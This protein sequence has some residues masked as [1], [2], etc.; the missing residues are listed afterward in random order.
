[1]K[2]KRLNY[3]DIARAFAI[4]FIVLGHTIVHSQHLGLLF[5]LLY[6]FH[7]AL[8]FIL[9][10][11]VFT[12]KKGESFLSFFKRK[13]LR[14]MIPYF[15]WALV[16]LIPYMI[17]GGDIGSKLGINSSF[18]LK[19]MLINVLYGNGNMEALK[20]NTSLWFLP[21]LFSMEIIYYF[22][23]KFLKKNNRAKIIALFPIILV[24]FLS[25]IYLNKFII[26][27]FG[28]N[29]VLNIGIFFYIGF[30][31]REFNI[32]D[33][34]INSC[35]ICIMLLIGIICCFFNYKNVSCVGYDYGN[36]VL[37]L[38]SGICLSLF[39]LYQKLLIK[40]SFL[41]I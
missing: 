27:P 34:M 32:I 12:I 23:I 9:S 37:A 5:K 39:Y 10:G 3:I 26:L 1:M 14:I 40:I 4:I 31:L 15:I 30:L 25:V 16:F 35:I 36:F 21:A 33:K 29:T 18:N 8:F 38:S 24:G 13:F 17:F 2:E 20:Q 28:I 11:F 7:I 19:T 6:S 41:N 22:I